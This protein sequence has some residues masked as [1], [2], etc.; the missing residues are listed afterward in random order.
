MSMVK[1]VYKRGVYLMKSTINI[2]VKSV[3]LLFVV[4]MLVSCGGAEQRKA[5]YLARGNDYLEQQNYDKAI[6]ELKNVLQIDPKYAEAYYLLGKAEENKT[7]WARAFG[8]Y[9]KA[10]EL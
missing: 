8:Y 5:K 6:V 9:S 4:M 2:G 10:V 1:A 3:V 7:N